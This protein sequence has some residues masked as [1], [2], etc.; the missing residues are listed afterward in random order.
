M[1]VATVYTLAAFVHSEKDEKR[2][3]IDVP[4][5]DNS[6]ISHHEPLIALLPF[7]ADGSMDS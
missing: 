2:N 6:S 3:E 7:L 1:A 4:L 5:S